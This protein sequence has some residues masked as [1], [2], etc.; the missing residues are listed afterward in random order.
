METAPGHGDKEDV[1][2][3]LQHWSEGDAAAGDALFPQVYDELRRMAQ[4]RMARERRD[5]TL[6]GTALVHEA[7]LRLSGQRVDR[8]KNRGQFLG[9]AS[10]MMRRVLVD[11]ARQRAAAKR[12]AGDA[13]LS[14]DDTAA[15]LALDAVIARETLNDAE[16]GIDLLSVDRALGELAQFDPQQARIV[17]LRYFGGLS[18]DQAAEATG[19]SASTVKREWT[20]ARAWLRRELTRSHIMR[21]S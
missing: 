17:E 12:G 10:Q 20:L 18:I 15:A 14:L 21:A 1:T 9:L 7:F 8:W 19:L 6:Q 5:H 11:H 16:A 13:A 3:L 4:R 2:S